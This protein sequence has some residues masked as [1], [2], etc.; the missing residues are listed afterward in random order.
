M[1]YRRIPTAR[2]SPMF[3]FCVRLRLK[4]LVSNGTVILPAPRLL[5]LLHDYIESMLRT[6][7]LQPT[8]NRIAMLLTDFAQLVP[9]TQ[10]GMPIIYRKRN[11][12]SLLFDIFALESEMS[13]ENPDDLVLCSSTDSTRTANH[14]SCAVNLLRGLPLST[15][16]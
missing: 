13:L 9:L 6:N 11:S 14:R 10:M 4:R 12:L 3:D 15:D 8:P 7:N 5:L 16:A 1:R 2:S